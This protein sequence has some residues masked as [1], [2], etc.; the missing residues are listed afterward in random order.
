M[1]GASGPRRS[2][3][4]PRVRIVWSRCESPCDG[5]SIGP[6]LYR[7]RLNRARRRAGDRSRRNAVRH[8]HARV[9]PGD[10]FALN[11]RRLKF[12]GVCLHHDLGALGAAVNRRAIERQLQT[13][14]AMGA[15]AVRTSHNP[16]APE[17]LDLADELGLLVI[18]EAFDMW[19]KAK[20]P[21]GHGKYFAEWGERDLRDMIRRDRNHPSIMLWSI[22]NEILEQADADGAAI[23]RRLT[24]ICHEEDPTRLVTA[25][26]NQLEN[27][28]RNGLAAA[29][30]VPG[31]NYQARHFAR[32][33][34]EHPGLDDLQRR[35]RV[36]ASAPAACTTCR[37]RS[38][39]STR[40]GRS[41]ASTSSPRLGIRAG[42]RVCDPGR[43]A[44]GAGRIRVDRVRLPGRAD[45]LLRL[46]RAA[47]HERLALPQLVLRHR[48]SGGLPEGSLLPVSEPVD[49]R[50]RW[51]TCCP[52]GTGRASRDS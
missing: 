29:V 6:A 30:D 49:A 33:L 1:H 18:D 36:H 28:I 19:G 3:H 47:G 22:G 51:C 39:R 46:A 40:P 35:E 48:R 50:R 5:T 32:V 14:K 45:A 4:Q 9:Q 37:S 7:G 8:P 41:R 12:Q 26:L 23:A 27:A 24:A 34:Q 21:N 17:L 13:M 44:A 10:G 43:A 25:G 38:T 2:R 15:N 42:L 20:V 31:F 16:P 52:T 11:G